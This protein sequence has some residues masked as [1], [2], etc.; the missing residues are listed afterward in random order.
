MQSQ[1]LTI[2][3]TV[4]DTASGKPLKNAV[5]L[6]SRL[7]DSVLVAYGRTNEYGLFSIS[8]L[9]VDTYQVIIEHTLFGDQLFFV[10]GNLKQLEID[11]GKIAMPPKTLS[12][13]EITVFGNSEAIFYK[14]DTLVYT[15]DSFKVKANANVED[16]LK[17]L[18]GIRVEKDGKI[19]SQGKAVDQVLVD[20]DEFFG[21]D[22]TIATR[23][24]NAS[25]IENVQVYEKKA[26]SVDAPNETLQVMNLTLKEEAKKGHFG[27][28]IAGS[29]GSNFHEGQALINKFNSNTKI[30]GFLIG[31]NTPSNNV[32]WE[33]AYKYG[34]EDAMGEMTMM[35]DGDGYM[36]S[37]TM[38]NDGLPRVLKGGAYYSD[39]INTKAKINLSYSYSQNSVEKRTETSTQ[40]FLEDST[41][42]SENASQQK[43]SGESNAFN[44]GMT[45]KID[46]L[47]EFEI[48]NKIRISNYENTSSDETDF[49]TGVQKFLRSNDIFSKT[50]GENFASNHLCKFSRNFKKK[51][52]SL[53]FNYNFNTTNGFSDGQLLSSNI[54]TVTTGNEDADQEKIRNSK[55]TFQGAQLSYTEPLTPKF[56]SEIG[57][58]WSR[59]KSNQNRETYDY[60]VLENSYNLFNG[61]LSN[62]FENLRF[63]NR[64]FTRFIYETKKIRASAGARGQH[65]NAKNVNL[66]D[67]SV[68]RQEVNQILPS[69]AVRIRT[70]DNANFSFRYSTSSRLPDINQIQPVNDNSNPNNIRI[71]N[72]ELLPTFK[73]KADITYNFWKAISGNNLWSS[74]NI[75]NT[76]N[77]FTNEITYD[78]QGRTYTRTVNVNGNYSADANVYYTKS[79][80]SKKLSI[81]PDI[82]A[83]YS[84]FKNF[85]GGRENITLDRGISSGVEMSAELE[86]FEASVS[87]NYSYSKPSSSLNN[88][89]NRPFGT[90]R[91]SGSFSLEIP[92][93]LTIEAEAEYVKNNQRAQGFNTEFTLLNARILFPVMKDK[94]MQL[95]VEGYDLLN[96]NINISRDITNNTITD[97]KT[98]VINRFY[99]IKL[100]YKFNS[101]NANEDDEGW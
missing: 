28:A 82:S 35:D 78:S 69:A 67:G 11:F 60:N 19:Y 40:N 1:T 79:F 37:R 81:A 16:L 92:K 77:D 84:R 42:F 20:G 18:P 21:S 15:A 25:G 24:L 34:I 66:I 29:N 4:S 51:F 70:Q 58:E 43:Q 8:N 7:A 71:G 97:T 55:N 13:K 49:N 17:K 98:N 32:D 36:Y 89:S 38:D 94:K 95:S 45:Y 50:N 47:T 46:T 90:D 14:G 39:K 10:L 44:F 85:I 57:Y 80:L 12:L 48:K 2:R 27:K 31:S 63:S 64:L 72:P 23:N 30:S 62:N 56:K 59:D 53:N 87:Y 33:D 73:H 93:L 54:A 5:V 74:I 86:N 76:A 88:A 9:P 65:V 75:T 41:F 26:E 96:Q 101:K 68:L 83:N 3:G 91:I 52:R 61:L 99:M 22:P 100:M 6:A